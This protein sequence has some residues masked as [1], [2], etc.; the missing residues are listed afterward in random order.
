MIL[1]RLILERLIFFYIFV[2]SNFCIILFKYLGER[3]ICVFLVVDFYEVFKLR[4]DGL[5]FRSS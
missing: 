1:D 4:I 5:G 2:E 3:F